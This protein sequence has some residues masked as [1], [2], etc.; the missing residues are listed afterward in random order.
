MNLP[1]RDVPYCSLSIP[2]ESTETQ[3]KAEFMGNTYQV[4]KP[5]Y[6]ANQEKLNL[7]YRGIA[8]NTDNSQIQ[9]DQLTKKSLFV[10]K[11]IS[12]LSFE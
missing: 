10:A 1:Y 7:K 5:I 2:V 12:Q 6:Q 11:L 8:L 4:R 3:T 9:K